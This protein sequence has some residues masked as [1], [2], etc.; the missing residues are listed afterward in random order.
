MSQ[1]FGRRWWALG[2]QQRSD[3]AEGLI[4]VDDGDSNVFFPWQTEVGDPT[5][6]TDPTGLTT[7]TFSRRDALVSSAAGLAG[8]AGVWALIAVPHPAEAASAAAVGQSA[9][10]MQTKYGP[11]LQKAGKKAL[12]GGKAGA[13]AAVTQVCSLMWLRTT[14]NYQYRYGSTLKDALFTL[15]GEGGIGRL[16]Q[17]LPFAIVQGPLSRFGDTAANA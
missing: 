5:D 16:Y 6:S 10:D 2:S 11:I 1:R 12:G 7:S 3:M 8:L 9:M 15:W 4:D 17:G 13:A 14:M